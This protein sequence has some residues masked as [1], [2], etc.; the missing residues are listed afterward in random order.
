MRIQQGDA[1]TT[2]SR[3]FTD[4][5]VADYRKRGNPVTYRTYAGVDHGGVVT[6]ARSAR[7]ATRY[8]R[9]RLR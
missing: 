6:D 9:A 3:P 2:S 4:Q 1:D 8:I 5:L 7:D